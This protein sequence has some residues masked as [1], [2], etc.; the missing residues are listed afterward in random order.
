M[1]IKF[2][3]K[4]IINTA[5]P[6][7]NY[8]AYIKTH[9]CQDSFEHSKNNISF[10]KISDFFRKSKEVNTK[11]QIP[12]TEENLSD[13]AKELSAG[14]KSTTGKIIPP[15]NL[16]NI[17]SP[18]EFKNLL[19]DLTCE[20]FIS[21]KKNKETGVYCIDL[22]YHSNF[23]RGKENVFDILDN[24]ANYADEYYKKTGKKFV[25]ALTDRDTLDSVR[26]AIRIIGENPEKFKNLK[27]VPSVKISYAHEAPNS[28]LKFENSDMLVYGINPYSVTMSNFIENL[29]TKRKAMIIS[30]IKEVNTLY[31]EFAYNLIE[32]AQQNNI[33]Y[34]RDF[35]L[36]NLY[37]RA[38]EYAETKGDT[39]IKGLSL[40]PKEVIKEADDIINKLG[41]IYIGSDKKAFSVLGS[42]II[43][44]SDVNKSIKNVFETYSTHED[45]K[46]GKVVSS[47]EN[48]YD[49]MITC[50][51]LQK[52]KPVIALCAPYYFSHYFEKDKTQTYSNVTDFIN[53]LQARSDGM[54]LA[55]ESVAPIYDLDANLKPDTIRNFNNYI[56][57]YTDLYE[58]GG[59]FAKRL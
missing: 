17:M 43:K 58:V 46:Q 29:I 5:F 57:Q 50:L 8:P 20:N 52:E 40:V 31:P 2:P 41:K 44:D 27:F 42:Q 47:A 38:R 4:Y 24:A 25:F 7:Y 15:Q 37:W 21:S 16:K 11:Q 19:P 56:R 39:A 6:K 55:F 54:L 14:I 18:N 49:E 10:G 30:F 59:S 32:F 22:D 45:K 12:K 23:S 9:T 35:T 1:E 13:F 36:S 34:K 48:L 26:H 51:S 3:S 28:Q 33:K 53:K